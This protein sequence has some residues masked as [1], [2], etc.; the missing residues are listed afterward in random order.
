MS[1]R[2]RC[3]ECH[4]NH[5]NLLA[6]RDSFSYATFSPVSTAVKIVVVLAE[7]SFAQ[8]HVEARTTTIAYTN[9]GIVRKTSCANTS[10]RLKY[11]SVSG[12]KSVRGC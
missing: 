7:F 5:T 8:D 6:Y 11:P 4:R 1:V 2:P 3:V 9:R 10:T 12:R